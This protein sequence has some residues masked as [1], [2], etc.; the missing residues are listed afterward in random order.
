MTYI[1]Q[2]NYF[3]RYTETIESVSAH[4]QLL[5]FKLMHCANRSGWPEW[6][7]VGQGTLMELAEIARKPTFYDARNELKRKGFID[8]RNGRKG[9][10]ARYHINPFVKQ[11]FRIT[12]ENSIPNRKQSETDKQNV[13]N[14]TIGVTNS[15]PNSVTNNVTN[16]VPNSVT[17]KTKSSLDNKLYKDIDVDIDIDNISQDIPYGISLSSN[18]DEDTKNDLNVKA[19]QEFWNNHCGNM[20]RIRSL[21]GQRLSYVKARIRQFGKEAV[22]EA[23]LNAE[24]SDLLNGGGNKGWM[25]SFDWIMRPNNFPKVLEGNYNN[26]KPQAQSVQKPVV[27]TQEVNEELLQAAEEIEA[28]FYESIMNNE[29]ES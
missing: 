3:N 8:F 11:G 4:A 28:Q 23:I 14:V 12:L 10:K 19:L 24:K 20:P 18:E 17:N 1:D 15:V 22:K 6:F 2:I 7:E 9:K 16:N 27:E 25:A 5:W 13:T 26:R 29:N 21:S